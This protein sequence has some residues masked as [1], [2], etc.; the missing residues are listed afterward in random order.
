MPAMGTDVER[1][2][3]STS[4]GGGEPPSNLA[5]CPI[6]DE[7]LNRG[8]QR[9]TFAEPACHLQEHSELPRLQSGIEGLDSRTGRGR[10][11]GFLFG[12]QGWRTSPAR[13]VLFRMSEDV[14]NFIDVPF[15][16]TPLMGS[17]QTGINARFPHLWQPV[18]LFARTHP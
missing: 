2:V 1:V 9:N 13:L 8:A 4:R 10:R 6:H 7:S 17:G 11:A 15:L 3:C 12:G 5:I 14:E 16:K 18:R